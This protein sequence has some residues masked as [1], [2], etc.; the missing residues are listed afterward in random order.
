MGRSSALL[1]L[2]TS[3]AMSSLESMKAHAMFA[4]TQFPIFFFSCGGPLCRLPFRWRVRWW[5]GS[6]S[7]WC[8]RSELPRDGT[9]FRTVHHGLI[10]AS[11]TAALLASDWIG[12]HVV[13]PSFVCVAPPPASVGSQPLSAGPERTV[14]AGPVFTHTSQEIH[15]WVKGCTLGIW[16][17]AWTAR[18]SSSCSGSMAR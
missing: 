5:S 10:T 12:K 16:L 13:R 3:R 18:N 6:G 2:L 14:I 15:A 1:W 9:V 11:F 17:M 7:R 4:P 8:G